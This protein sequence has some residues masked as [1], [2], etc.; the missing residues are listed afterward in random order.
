MAALLFEFGH[1]RIGLLPELCTLSTQGRAACLPWE[2]NAR[3]IDV[4]IHSCIA[5]P[6]VQ[7]LRNL[8]FAYK[9][10]NILI[11]DTPSI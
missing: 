2:D 11:R 7:R 9:A 10:M 8:R 1:L 3:N 4:E 6:Q 5:L